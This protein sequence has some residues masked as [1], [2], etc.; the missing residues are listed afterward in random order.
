GDIQELEDFQISY[1]LQIS[2]LPVTIRK[3]SKVKRFHFCFIG[4]LTK[5]KRIEANNFIL[6]LNHNELSSFSIPTSFQNLTNLV[7][8][9]LNNNKIEVIPEEICQMTNLIDLD[10]SNNNIYSLPED[11]GNLVSLEKLIANNNKIESLPDSI[12]KLSNLKSLELLKN[13]LNSLPDDIC[14]LSNLK[15]LDI[16][17]NKIMDL[18]DDFYLLT[19]LKIFNTKDNVW[20]TDI[21]PIVAGGLEKIMEHYKQQAVKRGKKVK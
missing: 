20:K 3:L 5:I 2:E 6:N 16:S 11:I 12:G 9:Y 4:N 7:R 19:N 1:N 14:H 13:S 15:Q 17:Y 18:P 10:I 8:L 21:Q